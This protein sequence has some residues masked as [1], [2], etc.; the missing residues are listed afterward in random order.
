MLQ[1]SPMACGRNS[2]NDYDRVAKSMMDNQLR[3][4][5]PSRFTLETNKSKILNLRPLEKAKHLAIQQ[6]DFK[7]R[8][9]T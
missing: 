1:V 8:A 4:P 7:Y 5:A 9:T 2:N 3:D 6:P